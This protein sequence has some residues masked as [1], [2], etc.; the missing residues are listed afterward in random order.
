MPDLRPV[1]NATYTAK[2]LAGALGGD[3]VTVRSFNLGSVAQA[4]RALNRAPRLIFLGGG[5]FFFA[6][7]GLTTLPLFF[8][9]PHAFALCGG[10]V[11]MCV[12]VPPSDYW[13]T[14]AFETEAYPGLASPFLLGFV[15]NRS[16]GPS[17]IAIEERG[18][19]FSFETSRVRFARWPAGR[20]SIQFWD[21]RQEPKLGRRSPVPASVKLGLRDVGLTSEALDAVLAESR[22]R[23]LTIRTVKSDLTTN[24]ADPG[25]L[26]SY[27]IHKGNWTLDR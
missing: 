15:A 7:W 9:P 21:Y 6:V 14:L 3:P 18:L 13:A 20:R 27:L 22:R 16:S 19:R 26:V 23:G 17:S 5:S 2:Q 11:L 8:S 1:P 12:T 10:K 4:T 25:M 24:S